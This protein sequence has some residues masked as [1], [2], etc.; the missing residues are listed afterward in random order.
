MVGVVLAPLTQRGCELVDFVVERD[1]EA[2]G[3]PSAARERPIQIRLDDLHERVARI[4]LLKT[5]NRLDSR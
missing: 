1:A 3:V 4:Q 2:P 5:E